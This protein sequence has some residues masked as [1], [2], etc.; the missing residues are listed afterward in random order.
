M[1]TDPL[2][3][4]EFVV[5]N[6]PYQEETTEKIGN[7]R[8]KPSKSIF[9]MFQITA[10]NI[11]NDVSVLIY[12][13]KRWMHRSGKGMKDFGLQQINDPHLARIDFYPKAQDIFPETGINDGITIVTKNFHKKPEQFIKTDKWPET[14]LKNV[15]PAILLFTKQ[16]SVNRSSLL[17]NISHTPKRKDFEQ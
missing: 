12:P 2:C 7:N 9:Q 4:Q 10:D 8:Q 17:Y 16:V 1:R 14:P 13:G 3:M 5:R 11:T 15:F 6:P